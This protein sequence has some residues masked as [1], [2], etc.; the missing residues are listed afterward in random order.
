[1]RDS[2]RKSAADSPVRNF[3]RYPKGSTVLCNQCA[4]PIFRLDAG[5]WLGDKAGRM[6]ERFKP[7][8]LPDVVALAARSDID[9]GVRARLKAMGLDGQRRHVAALRDVRAGDPMQCPA[10]GD[11]FV[12]VLSVDQ[13]ETLDKAYTIELLTIP[14]SGEKPAPVRGKRLGAN[15]D[16][17]H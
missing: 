9:A 6:A 11:C 5:I 8:T 2:L 12:Q 15:G 7:L 13:S 4:L 10:C 17:I 14:P 16:W 3:E 1:M